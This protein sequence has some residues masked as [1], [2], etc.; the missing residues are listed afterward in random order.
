M[1]EQGI[2][3]FI[4]RV[5]RAIMRR[6]EHRFI[7]RKARDQ[8]LR[9]V[10]SCSPGNILVLCYGNIYRSPFVANYLKKLFADRK[11]IYILN[12]PNFIRNQA[13]PL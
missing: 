11:D 9:H 6:I 13:D 2:P 12:Q 4:A 3:G 1:R 7:L 10:H 5:I 8:S